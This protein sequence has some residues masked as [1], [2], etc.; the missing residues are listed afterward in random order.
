MPRTNKP[1]LH[2][3]NGRYTILDEGCWEWKG[4]TM[5]NGYG[6]WSGTYPG[7]HLAHRLMYELTIGDPGNLTIDHLCRNRR[8]INPTHLE[9][10]S[11]KLNNNRGFGNQY[12]QTTHCIHGHEFTEDNTYVTPSTGARQ[13]KACI[14]AYMPAY[15]RAWRA[16]LQNLPRSPED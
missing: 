13:C 7:T 8:C 16:R 12:K 11:I 15:K 10:V 1:L 5:K 9:A 14:R 6:V 2:E 3:F 4:K